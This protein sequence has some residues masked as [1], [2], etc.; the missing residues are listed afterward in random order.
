MVGYRV[1]F[2]DNQRLGYIEIDWVYSNKTEQQ[3]Y[4]R[5]LFQG[6]D[7]DIVVISDR[8]GERYSGERYSG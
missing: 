5:L 3:V 1:L 8:T 6:Y 4:N 7:P 2:F